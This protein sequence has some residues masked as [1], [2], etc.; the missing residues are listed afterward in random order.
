MSPLGSTTVVATLVTVEFDYTY[1]DI[2]EGA[3]VVDRL[4][5]NTL[6]L[7]P[8]IST[9]WGSLDAFAGH[10]A[11]W[12]S[13]AEFTSFST[14]SA[15]FASSLDSVFR[16]SPPLASTTSPGAVPSHRI[17][18]LH[19]G[20]RMPS[21][22]SWVIYNALQL[23]IV[24]AVGR[25]STI[26]LTGWGRWGVWSSFARRVLCSMSLGARSSTLF[27]GRR[28]LAVV[29]AA[30]L[31]SGVARLHCP[32]PLEWRALGGPPGRV[33][34]SAAAAAAV[35]AVG[36][37]QAQTLHANEPRRNGHELAAQGDDIDIDKRQA[38][39]KRVDSRTEP[40]GG[41]IVDS[42]GGVVSTTIWW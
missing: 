26:S 1:P 39:A 38:H 10:R 32:L 14:S 41:G 29:V 33:V 27:V 2:F 9:L 13:P 5:A 12:G 35:I 23:V 28:D 36:L 6:R 19:M 37:S 40:S 22:S 3:L 16:S 42:S 11:V 24:S 15:P 34:A 17:D 20:Y 8:S 4:C 18:N 30:W 21:A 25:H 31:I 7:S